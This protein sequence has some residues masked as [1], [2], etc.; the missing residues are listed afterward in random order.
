MKFSVSKLQLSRIRNGLWRD[1]DFRLHVIPERIERTV[2]ELQKYDVFNN[3]RA[4]H[5]A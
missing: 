1:L 5:H 2:D 3:N 4:R